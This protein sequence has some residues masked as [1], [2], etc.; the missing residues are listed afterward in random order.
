MA[1]RFQQRRAA[2][3]DVLDAGPQMR[4]CAI[5]PRFAL[6]SLGDRLK[7]ELFDPGGQFRE[8]MVQTDQVGVYLFDD[9]FH[10]ERF[11]ESP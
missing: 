2:S 10:N 1:R 9:H 6:G 4:K 7:L 5:S 8:F 3:K 11:I